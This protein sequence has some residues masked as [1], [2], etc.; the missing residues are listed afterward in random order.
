MGHPRRGPV[1]TSLCPRSTQQRHT[2]APAVAESDSA[3]MEFLSERA[4][5]G[6]GAHGD[7]SGL[8]EGPDV[9]GPHRPERLL[10]AAGR[11]TH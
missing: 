1:V 3:V 7:P 11:A 9:G 2:P 4:A 10:D 5:H 6:S 8:G